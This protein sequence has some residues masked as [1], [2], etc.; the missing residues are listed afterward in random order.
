MIRWNLIHKLA[1]ALLLGVMVFPNVTA[2]WEIVHVSEI[3]P[4][5]WIVINAPKRSLY[6]VIDDRIAV[7]YPIAVP[8]KGKEWAGEATVNGKY[9]KPDWVPPPEVKADHPELSDLIPGG[10]PNNPM[11]VRAITLDRFEV[12]IHGTTMKMR[13]SIGSAASYGC[14]RMLNEDVVDLFNRISIGTPVLMI[15]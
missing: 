13:R 10:A 12:A 1:L 8:K 5:G 2:A 14:I 4:P 15:P 11:G 7:R 3:A 6:Y 9:I